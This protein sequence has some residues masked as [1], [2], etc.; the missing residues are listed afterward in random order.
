MIIQAHPEQVQKRRVALVTS[1]FNGEL[2][3]ELEAGA[4]ARLADQGM[5]PL[6]RV[7]VPGAL[8]IPLAVEALLKRRECEAV[9]ALGVVIRGET[10]HYDSVCQAVERGCSQL[11][12]KFRKPVAFGVLT[13][14][15]QTQAQARCGGAKGHKGVEALQA[16]LDM[17]QVLEAI[18]KTPL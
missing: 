2:T 5:E 10:T 18:R 16:A 14:E 12:L 3:K 15:N 1:L 17:L 8:E 7:Y 9:V 4:L 6:A 11:Q 13:T